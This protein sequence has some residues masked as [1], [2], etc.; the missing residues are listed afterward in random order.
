MWN[1]GVDTDSV[2][3]FM[4]KDRGDFSIG[5]VNTTLLV[6]DKHPLLILTEGSVCPNAEHMHAMTAVRFICDTSVFGSGT[7][8][9]VAQLPPED[10]NACSFF[11]EWRTHYACPAG[12][13]AGFWGGLTVAI[14]IIL[15]VGLMSYIVVRT[16]YNR[17]VLHLRGF[18]Q[19]P[20][21]SIFS[22]TDTLDAL[23]S[24][25]DRLLGKR[26]GR[27]WHEEATHG[28]RRGFE[29]LPTH[30]EEEQAIMG[31]GSR[32][33]S[34]DEDHAERQPN[35]GHA[36]EEQGQARGVDARGVIRL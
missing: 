21:F 28:G 13:D 33:P 2:A 22:F 23:Q 36:S 3:G 35:S 29:R 20:R 31:D 5:K 10:E 25:G 7:P 15:T 34:L 14:S 26:G 17:Y 32:G 8:Q 19:I 24:C 9:L 4:S 27:A 6:R 1:I 18:E 12:E 11:I 16:L 30:P